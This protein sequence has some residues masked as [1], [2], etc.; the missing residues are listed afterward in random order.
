MRRA[1]AHFLVIFEPTPN[2]LQIL[3]DAV[4]GMLTFSRRAK[5]ISPVEIYIVQIQWLTYNEI[6]GERASLPT[7]L[8]ATV[9]SLLLSVD[10][11][12]WNEMKT[13][14]LKYPGFYSFYNTDDDI[15]TISFPHPF[16]SH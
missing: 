9:F 4:V 1:V 15:L 16:R 14:A 12:A 7:R 13:H 3:V 11:A 6:V 10:T 5:T 2:I 8:A